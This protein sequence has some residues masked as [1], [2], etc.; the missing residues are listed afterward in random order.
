MRVTYYAFLICIQIYPDQNESNTRVNTGDL[1]ASL[2][3]VSG[4]RCTPPP[5]LSPRDDIDT[6]PHNHWCEWVDT[7]PLNYY[8]NRHNT[9]TPLVILWKYS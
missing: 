7:H 5:V 3:R 9:V 4:V 8:R 1:V 2:D 6:P